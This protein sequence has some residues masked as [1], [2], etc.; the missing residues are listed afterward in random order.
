MSCL[1]TKGVKDLV[2]T[3][4]PSNICARKGHSVQQVACH[5]M[6][7]YCELGFMLSLDW[8]KCFDTLAIGTV[9]LMKEFGIDNSWCQLCH[10]MWSR[11]ERFV[12]WNGSVH[13]CP[14]RTCQAIPQ[15][16]PWGPFV[17]M[18]WATSAFV[19]SEEIYPIVVPLLK[20]LSLWMIV[21]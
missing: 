10:N 4:I 14:L 11:Q 9:T 18:L 17:M 15:G 8:S 1:Q 16:D 19:I 21:L 6:E 20:R 2:Q 7:Q 12:S 3:K 5:I 13:S